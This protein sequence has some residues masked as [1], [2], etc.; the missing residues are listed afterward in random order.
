MLIYHVVDDKEFTHN[1]NSYV[2]GGV[3]KGTK[4]SNE[5]TP[6]SCFYIDSHTGCY[7]KRMICVDFDSQSS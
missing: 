2:F 6:F 4:P 5:M 3:L 7:E 1:K